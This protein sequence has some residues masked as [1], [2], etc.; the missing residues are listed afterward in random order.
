M[1]DSNFKLADVEISTFIQDAFN[2][3]IEQMGLFR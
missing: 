2:K 1:G 3:Y